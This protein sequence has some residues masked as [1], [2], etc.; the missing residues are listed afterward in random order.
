MLLKLLRSAN[1][2]VVD[3]PGLASVMKKRDPLPPF[4]R[5]GLHWSVLTGKRVAAELLRE[6]NAAL[7]SD[8]GE[9]V[10][11]APTWDYA[12]SERDRDLALFLNIWSLVADYPVGDAELDCRPTRE[13][14]RTKLVAVGGSFTGHL[15]D[16]LS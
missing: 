9:M 6:A 1:I 16:P 14:Q 2:R 13:G 11:G 12:A 10:V 5:G 8:F 4:P 7:G 3:G 15:L